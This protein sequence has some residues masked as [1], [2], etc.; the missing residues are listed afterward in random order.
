MSISPIVISTAAERDGGYPEV[1]RGIES[2]MAG[3]AQ[4]GYYL[5]S[6]LAEVAVRYRSLLANLGELRLPRPWSRG[7]AAVRGI[8]GIR[9]F[10]GHH[11][12]R[13]GQLDVMWR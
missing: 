3:T 4:M 8:G 6:K 1:L 12:R 9:R 10:P 13:Y 11:E 2:L 5:A 7:A